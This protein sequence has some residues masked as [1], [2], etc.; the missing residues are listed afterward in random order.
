M[1]SPPPAFAARREGVLSQKER[2]RRN[3][4]PT[5]PFTAG[6][7]GCEKALRTR[8][9]L[10]HCQ[11]PRCAAWQRLLGTYPSLKSE[12]ND[13]CFSGRF[14]DL[15]F[16]AVFRLPS[17]QRASGRR[18]HTS[19]K[20]SSAIQQRSCRGFA[21]R[22][23]FTQGQRPRAPETSHMRFSSCTFIWSHLNYSLIRRGL[24]P[25]CAKFVPES[26]HQKT[27][28]PFMDPEASIKHQDWSGE[29]APIP[30]IS[31]PPQF[32]TQACALASCQP[33]PL[34]LAQSSHLLQFPS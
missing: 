23:L 32:H 16:I 24:Q 33:I 6:L 21:P 7:G 31:R 29:V 8:L 2:T 17:A 34:C 3:Q 13:T 22:S 27:K 18:N 12:E 15:A 19:M 20:N 1:S 30:K 4:I 11:T 5:R 25:D 26:V 14:S 28:P 9:L 10:S